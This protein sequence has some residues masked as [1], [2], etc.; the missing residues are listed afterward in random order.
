MNRLDKIS[1]SLSWAEYVPIVSTVPAIVHLVCAIRDQIFP[2]APFV[3]PAGETLIQLSARKLDN[4]TH[5]QKGILALIPVIGNAILLGKWALN[6][7]ATKVLAQYNCYYRFPNKLKKIPDSLVNDG[8]FLRALP[9][10]NYTNIA[11][12]DVRF[13]QSSAN[14]R[15]FSCTSNINKSDLNLIEHLIDHNIISTHS[16]MEIDLTIR[17]D[18]RITAAYERQVD[19]FLREPMLGINGVPIQ[20]RYITFDKGSVEI[21]TYYKALPQPL[22][23]NVTIINKLASE[24]DY[25]TLGLLL[26]EIPNKTLYKDVPCL[27]LYALKTGIISFKDLPANDQTPD[28]ACAALKSVHP[29]SDGP[30]RHIIDIFDGFSKELKENPQVFT[31]YMEKENEITTAQ[32]H[33]RLAR[34]RQG[35]TQNVR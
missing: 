3:P 21:I 6:T 19:R 10:I 13:I 4:W 22:Q 27:R 29:F 23:L 33:A 31:A 12:S 18:P 15:L 11:R 1:N 14:D 28:A 5:L 35:G 7:I 32:E 17:N 16:Y 25:L 34:Q 20:G 9:E 24:L 30:F 26:S 8:E 2:K